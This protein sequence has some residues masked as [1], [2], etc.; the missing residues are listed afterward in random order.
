MAKTWVTPEIERAKQTN[1]DRTLCHCCGVHRL[2][3]CKRCPAGNV[4]HGKSKNQVC[5]ACVSIYGEVHL[6]CSRNCPRHGRGVTKALRI[7]W[8][9]VRNVAVI[10]EV[11]QCAAE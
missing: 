6:E 1:K 5:D 3:I 2:H 4:Q 11:E 8:R 9:D 10:T 7:Q